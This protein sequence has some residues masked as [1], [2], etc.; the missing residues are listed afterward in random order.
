MIPKVTL[1]VD[2]G[3]DGTTRLS[4]QINKRFH[5]TKVTA[6]LSPQQVE[7]LAMN[8]FSRMVLT[9]GC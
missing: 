9:D 6:D 1:V 5:S 7:M 2:A 4:V 8:L 3:P